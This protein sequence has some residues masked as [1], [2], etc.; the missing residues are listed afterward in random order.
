MKLIKVLANGGS[1]TSSAY[2]SFPYRYYTKFND[3]TTEVYNSSV[4]FTGMGHGARN[5]L[6]AA[7]FSANYLHPEIDLVIFWEFTINDYGYNPLLGEHLAEKEQSMFLAWFLEV[8]R[9][10]PLNPPKLIL[11]GVF[12]E[13]TV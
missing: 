5:S 11:F 12:V 6:H 2:C 9:L 3:F 8:E 13:V 7:L 10:R 4:K 1:T